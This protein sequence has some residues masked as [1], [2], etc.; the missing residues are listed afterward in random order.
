MSHEPDERIAVLRILDAAANRAGE[1]LRVVEDYVRFALDDRGLTTL[2]KELRHAFA[3]AI[4]QMSPAERQAARET[5]ADV[6]TAIAT[7]TERARSDAASV[8]AASLNRAEQALRSLE[9]FSKTIQPHLGAQFESLRYRLYTLERAITITAD[10]IARLD[11]VRLYVLIDGRASE[12]ELAEL[13]EALFAASV[14][15]LQLR[16]QGL[17]DRE[18]SARAR[19]L[20]EISRRM[21]KLLIV[22]DRAD[23]AVLAGADGVHLGQEDLSVKEARTIVGPR[24]LIGVSTHSIQQAREAVLAGANY[25]GV[26]PTFAS[27]TKQFPSL[28]GVEL[29]Q[30][31]AAEIRLPSFAIGG[32]TLDNL[33]AVLATGMR[34]VAVSGAVLLDSHPASAMRALRRAAGI[35]AVA[36]KRPTCSTVEQFGDQALDIALA[37][38]LVSDP[39]AADHA[40][41]IEHQRR[42]ITLKTADHVDRLPA[43]LARV[44]IRGKIQAVRL[45]KIARLFGQRR[46]ILLAVGFTRDGQQLEVRHILVASRDRGDVRNLFDA[47]PAPCAPEIQQRHMPLEI[48]KTDRASGPG[49]RRQFQMGQSTTDEAMF[50]PLF[51]IPLAAVLE[52]P[53]R[54]H[55]NHGE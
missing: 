20:V 46:H 16:D 50:A 41:P 2:V 1:G 13:A 54:H 47:W 22:N 55:R 43:E 15:A 37:T 19:R 28:M 5:R 42:G 30:A 45:E 52:H 48:F 12:S 7:A 6:G 44:V 26:G 39:R 35:A 4:A 17:A 8:A 32:I 33:P 23:L 36:A 21:N 38:G 40:L 24:M 10:S 11:A 9:E 25:I 27:A 18:L 49:E 3:A 29:L 51:G 14:D 34:R 31:V 53:D